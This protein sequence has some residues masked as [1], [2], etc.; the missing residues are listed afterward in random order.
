MHEF[1]HFIG[2]CPDSLGHLD[3]LDIFI[4]NYQDV[5]NLI[6]RTYNKTKNI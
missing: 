6:N 5:I 2:I 4:S 1:I 3:L